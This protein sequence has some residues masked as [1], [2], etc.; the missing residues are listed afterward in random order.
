V[1]KVANTF[2]VMTKGNTVVFTMK[3]GDALP[4]VGKIMDITYIPTPPGRPATLSGPF[5]VLRVAVPCIPCAKGCMT[6]CNQ[7]PLRH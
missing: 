5:T 1:N 2:T 6:Y 3:K 4:E 7:V